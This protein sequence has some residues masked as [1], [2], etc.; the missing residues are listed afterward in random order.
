[1]TKKKLPA[2]AKG[3]KEAKDECL[4]PPALPKG[5]LHKLLFKQSENEA[6]AIK[7]YVEWQAHGEETVL[8]AEKAA[9]ERIFGR[10]HDV[11]DVHTDKERWWVVTGPTNLYSQTL[12]PSLDYTLSFHIGLMARV[13]ARREPEGSEAEQEF[14]LVTNRKMVQASEAFDIAD[15]AEE[16]QAVGMRCR[17]CLL[18]LIRELTEGS[19][20]TGAN[21]LP[22][23]GDFPG[24]ND[25]VANA[26]AA[27]SSAEHVR[28]YLKTTGERA[29]RLVNWLTHAA[30]A[31]RDDA[32]LGLSA[33]SHVISN[34]AAWAVRRKADAPERCARC[35]SYRITVDWRPDLGK[36][37]LY[38][39]RCESCGAEKLPSPPPSRKKKHGSAKYPT[40]DA[41]NKG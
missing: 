1:M 15:E 34:Y 7:D 2:Q 11:W 41:G 5:E 38:V 40:G 9:S 19:D 26:L 32:E 12:M 10:D 25:R 17:E 6:K 29:W 28:G 33:T 24:W 8:H 31:T 4:V 35:K 3:T 39:P 30:N 27:G 22:K 37:G 13:A 20:L 18:A 36:T 21:D 16:F 23:A 14:L